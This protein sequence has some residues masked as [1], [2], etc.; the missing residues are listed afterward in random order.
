M[1]KWRG[2]DLNYRKNRKGPFTAGGKVEGAPS[3]SEMFTTPPAFP[4]VSESIYLD[5]R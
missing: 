2:Q 1:L 3:L 5:F 4:T